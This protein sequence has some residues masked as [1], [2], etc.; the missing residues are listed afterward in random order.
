MQYAAENMRYA[1]RIV[2]V[3]IKDALIIFKGYC[4]I[5]HYF[6]LISQKFTAR[7][8]ESDK[9]H[10]DLS[11]AII[12]LPRQYV[13]RRTWTNDICL[14]QC[15][16]GNFTWRRSIVAGDINFPQKHCCVTLISLYNWQWRVAQKHTNMHCCVCPATMVT[17]THYNDRI[18]VLWIFSEY[19]FYFIIGEIHIFVSY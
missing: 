2:K 5:I 4:L 1:C 17:Q 13:Q 16:N 18:Y 11:F 15:S 9:L 8:T 3:R 19:L 14:C 10:N 12:C 7:L 6:H